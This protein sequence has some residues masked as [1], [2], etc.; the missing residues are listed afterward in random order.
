MK[1]A[2][3]QHAHSKRWDMMWST[4]SDPAS[5]ASDCGQAEVA[6]QSEHDEIT[7]HPPRCSL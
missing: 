1:D 7:A 3:N 4:A 2:H 6:R 5:D